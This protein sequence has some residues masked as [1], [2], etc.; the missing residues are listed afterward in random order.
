[1]RLGKAFCSEGCASGHG[2]GCHRGWCPLAMV[3]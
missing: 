1:M 2:C 3:I